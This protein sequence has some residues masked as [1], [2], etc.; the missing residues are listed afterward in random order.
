M[1]SIKE[2]LALVDK[3]AK[4]YKISKPY[5]VGGIPRD[6]YLN[7]GDIRTSDLDLTT[8]GKDV[9]RLGLLTAYEL[10]VTFELAEDGHI[11]VFTDSFDI[12]FSSNFI[13]P[14]VKEHLGMKHK[15]TQEAFSRDFTINTL[16]Q[17]LVTGKIEDPTGM[18][19]RD[20]E[21]MLI[22]TP[23]NP[24]ITMTDDPRRA[25]RA[26][27]LA[28][29]YG[30]NI[31]P[32]LKDYIINNPELFSQE[33]IK[34]KYISVKMIKALKVDAKKTIGLLKELELFKNVPLVGFFKE[35]LIEN[36]LLAE[37]LDEG[38]ADDAWR[39]VA[40]SRIDDILKIALTPSV[41]DFNNIQE[42]DDWLEYKGKGPEFVN[43]ANW[44]KDNYKLAG[45]T[46]NDY[47]TFVDWYWERYNADWSSQHASPEKVKAELL[48][49]NDPTENS[50]SSLNWN[51][52]T[53]SNIR[54]KRNFNYKIDKNYKVSPNAD[55]RSVSDEML[56]FA[57]LVGQIALEM[58]VTK[59]IISSG[60]RS[61]HA[62]AKVMYSNWKR[63]GGVGGGLKYLIDLYANDS[64][65][66]QIHEIFSSYK[67]KDAIN[68]A[69]SIIENQGN[70]SSHIS[71]RALDF[72]LTNDIKEVLD[73]AI[74]ESPGITL[75]REKDHYHVATQPSSSNTFSIANTPATLEVPVASERSDSKSEFIP[76]QY[77]P[78]SSE[79]VQLFETAA[80]ISGLPVE[81]AK[82]SGLHSL[83]K[84]ESG[85]WVGIPNFTYGRR[86][87]N[88][89]EWAK[90]HDELRDGKVTAKASATGLGQLL[91]K[92]VSIYYPSGLNGIGKPLE[93][94]I[95]MLR[96][97]KNRYKTPEAAW[98][99][100]GSKGYG[101]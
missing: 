63:H 53:G 80:Q 5:L 88:I 72:K 87:K 22:R 66:T 54:P 95:G 70:L 18:A 35:T 32:E 74:S 16:H 23:V 101:Y 51:G 14:A 68:Y 28:V 92:N 86:V 83:L 42:F 41:Q 56:E 43:F 59:P 47:Q 75:L 27:N 93:E 34:D 30:F 55:I 58:G 20:I 1:Y 100:Y 25:Y 36:K 60:Y 31:A 89:K 24:A 52:F 45:V 98:E 96:Y 64:L 9:L 76:K 65:V 17:D 49:L 99:Q 46:N 21:K 8:N 15:N 19:F 4:K 81:W 6:V 61:P 50:E 11:T 91:S 97:I 73:R 13:S 48:G 3:I 84:E 90:I 12:D 77:V 94:A 40:S 33:N 7:A 82:S 85:G 10:N 79:A 67:K 62:Q 26:V 2:T 78:F 71:G 57:G 38:A 39:P 37:Y 29:R 44:W 69:G